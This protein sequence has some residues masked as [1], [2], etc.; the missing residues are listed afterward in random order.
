MDDTHTMTHNIAWK[1]R[2]VRS[3]RWKNGDWIPGLKPDASNICPTP[4]TGSAGGACS[5]AARERL[6]DRPR[7]AEERQLHRHPGHRPAGPGD[8]RMHGEGSSIVSLEH[9]RAVGPHDR[10]H[11]P[12]PPAGR[13]E[14][15]NEKKVPVTVDHPDIYLGS[16]A[17]VRGAG[18]ARLARCLCADKMQTAKSPLGLLNR[19]ATAGKPSSA[20]AEQGG[21]RAAP[22]S[23]RTAQEA[24]R[25]FEGAREDGD[26]RR[27]LG[28]AHP[29]FGGLY[30]ATAVRGHRC[31]DRGSVLPSLYPDGDAAHGSLHS[32]PP[33]IPASSTSTAISGIARPR[34]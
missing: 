23:R 16:A 8:D 29:S 11:T 7:H 15:M 32:T 24:H 31:A 19:A 14:L 25:R 12:A 13:P 6:P 9:P 4:T 5:G 3:R 2:R 30:G 33:G 22:D 21:D 27:R 1:Q 10:H 28:R 26:R 18:R 34:T 20:R 17:G